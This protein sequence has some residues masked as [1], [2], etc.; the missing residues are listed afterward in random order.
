MGSID[1]KGETNFFSP[2][3]NSNFFLEK[4]QPFSVFFVLDFIVFIII[5]LKKNFSQFFDTFDIFP[6]ELYR[7]QPPRV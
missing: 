5:I 7:S 4:F 2:K 1:Y 6:F 3:T